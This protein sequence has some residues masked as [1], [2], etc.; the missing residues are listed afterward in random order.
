[1]KFSANTKS[2]LN[3]KDI[4][5]SFGSG[6]SRVKAV[7]GVS[8]TVKE[9]EI[10]LIMGPSGSGKTTFL[11]MLGI[12]LR[13]SSGSISINGIDVTELNEIQLPK[14]RRE[15]IGFMFQSSNLLSSLTV[16]E[17][18]IVPLMIQKEK[19]S[20][21][22]EKAKVLLTRLKLGHR[23]YNLP[24]DLSGGEKQRVAFARALIS[25]PAIILADEPTASVDSKMGRQIVKLLCDSAD[26]DGKAIIIVSH[27]ER[28]REHAH[29]VIWLE[30][31]RFIKEEKGGREYV[32]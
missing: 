6:S 8:L 29:R 20:D 21:A 31:G 9:K 24:K 4:T 14:V 23:L 28:I 16:L 22:I 1:M 10:V 30:D 17:N 7:K 15:E 19:R 11:S 3:V 5:R 12:L 18:T 27:D 2:V 13:P 25:D 32:Y 26:V